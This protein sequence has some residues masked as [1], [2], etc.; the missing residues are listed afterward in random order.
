M[1][2]LKTLV[3]AALFAAVVSVAPASVW[4]G[5]IISSEAMPIPDGSTFQLYSPTPVQTPGGSASVFYIHYT[6]TVGDTFNSGT[7]DE[8]LVKNGEFSL[9]SGGG[10]VPGTVTFLIYDR[11]NSTQT[12]SFSE[13]L[14]SASFAGTLGGVEVTLTLAPDTASPG[15]VTIE[16]L[17]DGKYKITNNHIVE[18]VDYGYK[19]QDGI[20]HH[21]TLPTLQAQ[22][23]PEP[24]TWVLLTPGLLALASRHRRV[25]VR[26]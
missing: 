9:T 10:S 20:V 14:T 12:G 16:S 24:A 21:V 26:A 22:I 25:K 13:H 6:S 17:P 19:D 1:F 23:L 4:A 18:N 3:R 8:T 5:Y 7:G 11:A 15:D 2:I